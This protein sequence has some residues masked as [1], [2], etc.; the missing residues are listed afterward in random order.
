MHNSLF[1]QKLMC[2][3]YPFSVKARL[4]LMY[5]TWFFKAPLHSV[6]YYVVKGGKNCFKDCEKCKDIFNV[7]FRLEAIL[8]GAIIDE[9]VQG[10][11]K[12]LLNMHSSCFEKSSS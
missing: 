3:N 12:Y 2:Y 7:G 9:L 1:L 8:F 4:L 6:C 11:D 5:S 10:P